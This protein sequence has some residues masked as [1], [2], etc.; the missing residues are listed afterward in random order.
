MGIPWGA[1]LGRIYPRWRTGLLGQQKRRGWVRCGKEAR[2]K[3]PVTAGCPSQNQ[4]RTPAPAQLLGW[5][6]LEVLRAT[7]AATAH[8]RVLRL[9]LEL[10]APHA[11]V[12][13]IES[14]SVEPPV[15]GKGWEKQCQK[16]C[17]Q[18]CL[19]VSTDPPEQALEMISLDIKISRDDKSA[20][21]PSCWLVYP[22]I[23]T[24]GIISSFVLPIP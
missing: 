5:T 11:V 15:R 13:Q 14:I 23:I 19:P 24:Q 2:C 9:I 3:D 1:A 20:S 7:S 10:S 17:L 4:H 8:S 12:F 6:L 21:V 16:E 22:Y 18:V